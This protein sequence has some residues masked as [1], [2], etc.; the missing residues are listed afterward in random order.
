MIVRP[1][2]FLALLLASGPALAA[3][4]VAYC[5][6][7]GPGAES[8]SINHFIV[9]FIEAGCAV[10]CPDGSSACCVLGGLFGNAS[11]TCVEDSAG[12]TKES[13]RPISQAAPQKRSLA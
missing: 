11:C 3:D 12:S 1:F 7:G 2:I 6:S 9:P 8:C 5:D 10:S 13:P 4:D